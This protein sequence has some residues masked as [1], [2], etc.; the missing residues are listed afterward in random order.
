MAEIPRH[1]VFVSYHHE[2]Q[3]YKDRFVQMMNGFMVDKSVNTGD[4][5]DSGLYVDE[6]RR[7]IRDD[8]IAEAT[9]TVVLVGPCTW[10]RKHVDWEIAASLT[11]TA[12]NDRCGLLGI[13]LPIHTDSRE[14]EYD[15]R[16]LPRRLA[17][18]CDG[19]DPFAAVHRWSG[20]DNEVN[21]VRKW[22]DDA[23]SRRKRQPDP[24]NSYRLFADNR[25]TDCSRGW[26][27]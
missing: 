19:N 12:H 3:E 17:D 20:S 27:S 2:D 18:N 23:F 4:I 22:I 8:Y 25:H 21:R 24:D 16:L 9:V 6:I 5:I 10:Q 11:D 26:P 15:P 1:K 7:R 13:R 14:A